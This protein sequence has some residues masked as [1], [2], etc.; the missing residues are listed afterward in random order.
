MYIAGTRIGQDAFYLVATFRRKLNL[1]NTVTP[2]LENLRKGISQL[3]AWISDVLQ[4][5]VMVTNK[6]VL[7][8]RCLSK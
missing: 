3:S 6:T 2:A 5:E 1:V 7:H 4:V 8:V